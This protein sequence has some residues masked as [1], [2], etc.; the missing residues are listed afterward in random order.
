MGKILIFVYDEMADFEF[1]L[2]A[3]LLKS[4]LGKEVITVSYD[5]KTVT[6]R[7]GA[8]YIPDSKIDEASNMDVEGLIIP[9][10]YCGSIEN[11]L[12]KLINN[13]NSAGIL[14]AAI[15]AAPKILAVSGVLEG[16]KY[17]TSLEEWTEEIAEIFGKEDPFPRKTYIN[18]RVVKDGNIITAKG[19]AFVDFAVEIL[20]YFDPENGEQLAVELLEF[21]KGIE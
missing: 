14:V 2:A 12:I 8:K 15:C 18:K 21:Y 13:L 4:V 11:N 10:G 5:T 1:T 19:Y 6:G 16:R 3:H 7:S 20:K 9:G 17:T